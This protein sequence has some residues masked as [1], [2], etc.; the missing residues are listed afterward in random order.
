MG[1]S[2]INPVPQVGT[3]FIEY[4]MKDLLSEL[5]VN[6][7]SLV[8]SG[9]VLVLG[10]PVVLALGGLLSEATQATK[11]SSQ[12]SLRNLE[13]ELVQGQL[14]DACI[15]FVVAKADS[16]LEREA[17]TELDDYFGGDVNHAEVCKW[18]FS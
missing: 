12:D 3:Y 14:T 16:K 18:V 11:V 7:S 1:S 17:K 13:V 5:N 4:T 6:V 15:K 10:A 2:P 8:R 9:V